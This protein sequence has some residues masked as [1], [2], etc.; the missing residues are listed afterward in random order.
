[1]N[2]FTD[3][4]PSSRRLVRHRARRRPTT[5][6]RG[7]AR[8]RD[9]T[10]A[11]CPRPVGTELGDAVTTVRATS[12][13][14]RRS[15]HRR[16]RPGARRLP[17]PRVRE[18]RRRLVRRARRHHV[19]ALH[20]H[21]QRQRRRGRQHRPGSPAV[22]GPRLGDR[23]HGSNIDVK[24]SPAFSVYA[25]TKAAVRSLARSWAAEL[26]DAGVR[27]RRERRAAR[28]IGTPGLSGLAD[29]PEDAGSL[30]D[31]LAA[32]VPLGRLG[33][34]DEIAD[35]VLFLG[36]PRSSYVTARSCTW[37]AARARCDA[38]PAGRPNESDGGPDHVSRP[39]T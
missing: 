39:V 5:R 35:A 10:A 37:T 20:R 25:A 3:T 27:V 30:L 32:G 2:D 4:T 36:S 1:M 21:V 12:P 23:P 13:T 26:V 38:G 31:G 6:R 33:T 22:P 29:T 9:R 24:A 34:E 16:R 14:R 28:P 11:V 17:R 7:R 18:R 8:H 19:G 15:S